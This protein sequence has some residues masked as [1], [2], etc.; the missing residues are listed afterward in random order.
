MRFLES[1]PQAG[2]STSSLG[3]ALSL[4]YILQSD[5]GS[6]S[7]RRN[8][9]IFTSFCYVVA[10]DIQTRVREPSAMNSKGSVEL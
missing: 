4:K 2:G 6:G 7:S 9:G 8:C 3:P 10:I 5:M 1:C